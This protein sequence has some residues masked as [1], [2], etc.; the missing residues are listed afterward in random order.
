MAMNM[1]SMIDDVYTTGEEVM[2]IKSMKITK[3]MMM[4]MIMMMLTVAN[5]ADPTYCDLATLQS[6]GIL[7]I[8]EVQII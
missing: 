6:N 5:Y 4:M 1:K 3:M 7:T 2:M 8:F